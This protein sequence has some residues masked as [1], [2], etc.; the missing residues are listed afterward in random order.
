[1]SDTGEMFEEDR[2]THALAEAGPGSAQADVDR[3]LESIGEFTQ[4]ATQHDDMTCIAVRYVS[5]TAE[6]RQAP[7]G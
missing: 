6:S 2:L 4:G 5:T 3:V 7:A 1:V